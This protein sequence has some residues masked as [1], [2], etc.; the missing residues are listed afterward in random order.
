MTTTE[1]LYRLY[2]LIAHIL[3]INIMQV[4]CCV[5]RLNMKQVSYL[6]ILLPT[7]HLHRTFISIHIKK[8]LNISAVSIVH[9]HRLI[10]YTQT[11]KI[12]NM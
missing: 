10:L 7:C 8:V 9:P 6:V 5:L 4:H 11:V 1:G 2:H 3:H 12:E